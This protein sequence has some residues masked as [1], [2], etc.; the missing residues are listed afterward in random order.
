MSVILGLGLGA[1]AQ[2]TPP[3][4]G[5]NASHDVQTPVPPSPSAA[6]EAASSAVAA[7][8]AMWA[9]AEV[10]GRTADPKH[11]RLDDH[12]EKNALWLLQYVMEQARKAGVTITGS[13]VVEPTV[14]KSAK[15]EVEL[16]DC[17]DGSKWV[18]AKP[19]RSSGGLSGGRRRA[20]ATVDRISGDAWKVSDLHWEEVGTC[21]K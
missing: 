16:R 7:Y 12:A 21:I 20:Q 10:A 1:C 13:V 3:A 4:A 14:V 6:T 11:P 8:R 19:G 18:Q 9:D 2:D 17:V 15:D 5:V